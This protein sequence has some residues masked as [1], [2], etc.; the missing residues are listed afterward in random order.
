ML[1]ALC[2]RKIVKKAEEYL[3][4]IEET[5]SLNFGTWS[6]IYDNVKEKRKDFLRYNT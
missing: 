4:E 3:N 5:T 2:Y 6:N 1:I